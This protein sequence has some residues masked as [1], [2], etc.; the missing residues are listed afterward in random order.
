MAEKL[1]I[2][3]QILKPFYTEEELLK[4]E[5]CDKKLN[6]LNANIE[7]R[8]DAEALL[9]R[10]GIDVKKDI[11]YPETDTPIEEERLTDNDIINIANNQVSFLLD[12]I[13]SERMT[14]YNNVTE[15]Y[16]ASFENNPEAIFDDIEKILNEYDKEDYLQDLEK[17]KELV[18]TEKEK[19]V[20][21]TPTLL[22]LSTEGYTTYYLFLQRQLIVQQTVVDTFLPGSDTLYHI[23]DDKV[24]KDY[25]RP[26]D[27]TPGRAVTLINENLPKKIMAQ[28]PDVATQLLSLAYKRTFDR[29]VTPEDLL[30]NVIDVSS[31]D[32]PVVAVAVDITPADINLTAKEKSIH[33]A[34][35]SFIYN[36]QNVFTARQVATFDLYGNNPYD[37]RP[38]EAQVE[39]YKK[40]IEDMILTRT[41]IDI[42]EH[43]RACGYLSNDETFVIENYVLPLKRGIYNIN[44]QEVEAYQKIDNPPF[45]EYGLKAKEIGQLPAEALNIP[46][47]SMT[48]DNKKIRN[49]LLMAIKSLRNEKSKSWGTELTFDTIFEKAEIDLPED[50]NQLKKKRSKYIKDIK[51]MLEKWTAD[52]YIHSYTLEKKKN[53]YYKI[54][55][56]L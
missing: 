51:S 52:G 14:I 49:Y 13:V 36:G 45:Y 18:A 21:I 48:D 46:K 56:A 38:S 24:S 3:D 4:E 40:G 29:N 20:K 7:T 33:D 28:Q 31:K 25:I 55:M 5:E 10:F 2:Q 41:K 44:G 26:E 37:K 16:R 43:L 27:Y 50:K 17:Y 1:S 23:L 34:V 6:A 35:C 53:A 8:E 15:R 42:S 11:V 39:K 30:Q 22:R 47:V 9:K 32:K 12:I 19:N 54:T